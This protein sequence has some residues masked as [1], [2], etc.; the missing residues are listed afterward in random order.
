MPDLAGQDLDFGAGTINVRCGKGGKDRTAI[1]SSVCARLCRNSSSEWHAPQARSNL[2][3][4][5]RATVWWAG[6]KNTQRRPRARLAVRLPMT[7]HQEVSGLRANATQV[8]VGVDT[9]KTLQG[10]PGSSGDRQARFG[11]YAE[12][13]VRYALARERCRYSNDPATARP[14]MHQGN[15][16]LYTHVQHA[17]RHTI[18]PWISR[19]DDTL[20]WRS[21]ERP[22]RVGSRPFP[23]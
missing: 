18:S 21:P 8:C 23:S 16:G 4:R 1:L 6:P 9:S 12:A 15:N 7:L 13:L 22:V 10:C 2:G 14:Q 17:I 20:T 5:A 11:R 19:S 3:V